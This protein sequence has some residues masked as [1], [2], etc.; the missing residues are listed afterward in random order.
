MCRQ[1]VVGIW[2]HVTDSASGAPLSGVTGQVQSGAYVD[3]LRDDG[4]GDGSTSV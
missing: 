1:C 2:V 3:T 4:A